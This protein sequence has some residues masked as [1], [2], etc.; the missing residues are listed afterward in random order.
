M[1]QVCGTFIPYAPCTKIP[2][3]S[4]KNPY[5]WGLL[6]SFI[7][8]LGR[9]ANRVEDNLRSSVRTL[10]LLKQRPR[11]S[12]ELPSMLVVT[13]GVRAWRGVITPNSAMHP[14]AHFANDLTDILY[15]S[16]ESVDITA[17]CGEA[18]LGCTSRRT[19][20]G[21]ADAIAGLWGASPQQFSAVRNVPTAQHL[22]AA[23]LALRNLFLAPGTLA[24]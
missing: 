8:E 20:T 15:G 16:R 21:S 11:A 2:Q 1:R 18:G 5:P 24:H 9:P 6:G 17:R 10:V 23:Q 22:L 7:R 14:L 12:A 4:V 19:R 3:R 13:D